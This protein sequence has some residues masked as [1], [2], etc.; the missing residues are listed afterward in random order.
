M[1]VLAHSFVV[2]HNSSHGLLELVDVFVVHGHAND[3]LWS[4]ASFTMMSLDLSKEAVIVD[5]SELTILLKAAWDEVVIDVIG[6]NHRNSIILDPI[7]L[8][9]WATKVLGIQI[10]L[11][12]SG[13]Y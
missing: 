13:H 6:L 9:D 7:G 1:L 12:Q 5:W 4:S 2:L 10:I 3:K 8:V 11:F